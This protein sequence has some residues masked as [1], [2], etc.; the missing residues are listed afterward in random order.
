M[1]YDWTLQELL[2]LDELPLMQLVD[3]AHQVHRT[4]HEVGEVQV[5]HL[6]SVKTGG[7]Q[8]DCRYCAQSSRYKTSI[9][10]K[11]MM[12]L[13]E[14]LTAAREAVRQGA[15]RICLSVAWREIRKGKIFD[16]MLEMVKGVSAMNVEVCCTMGMADSAHLEQLKA[17]GLHAYNHNLDTSESFYPQIITTRCYADRIATLDR[18]QKAGLSI[19]CGGIIGLGEETIDRL[20]LLLTVAQRNPHPESFPINRLVAVPGTPL[21]DRSLL[22]FWDLLRFVAM[23]RIVLPKA[24]V[25][26]SAGRI[27]MSFEQQALCFFAGANSMFIGDKLL[28][29]ANTPQDRDEE[30]FA[31]LGLKVKR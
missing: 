8:E 6:I 24:M 1:R 29:V 10:A 16:Q 26:L 25:R 15:T 11:P 21:E 14:V 12:T 2:A 23:A 19:C 9:I 7:C 31:L 4:F 3:K 5:G 27:E 20:K 17:A 30:M 22:S 28:T 13:D 18:V